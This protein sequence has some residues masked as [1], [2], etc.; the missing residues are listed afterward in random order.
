MV[1]LH[2]DISSFSY[3]ETV[4][5]G[6]ISDE[7]AQAAGQDE[8]IL[9]DELR[10]TQSR[11]WLAFGMMK[12]I[13]SLS[14]LP[15]VLKKHAADFLLVIT[16]NCDQQDMDEDM[17]CSIFTPHVMSTLQVVSFLVPRQSTSFHMFC[18]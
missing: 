3:F 8:S 4:I 5:W 15:C 12:Y 16:E 6:H 13:F 2:R 17:I 18:L 14:N 11:R 10:S 7:V 9:K 1:L